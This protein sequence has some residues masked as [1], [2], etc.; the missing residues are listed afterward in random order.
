QH[1]GSASD[2]HFLQRLG[3]IEEAHPLA[4][5]RHEWIAETASADKRRHLELIERAHKERRPVRADIDESRAVRREGDIAREPI[6]G[7]RRGARWRDL[8]PPYPRRRDRRSRGEPDDY[9]SRE[10]T[11]QQRR[12]RD[13]RAS[14][15][16]HVE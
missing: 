12:G 7:E 13:R 2:G 6:D 5:G 15:P 9:S 8:E 14:S 1:R 4:I 10:A 3:S 11:D 16:R